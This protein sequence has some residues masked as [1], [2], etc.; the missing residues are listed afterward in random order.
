MRIQNLAPTA[1]TNT[2]AVLNATLQCSGTNADVYVHWGITDGTTNAG[3]WAGS[4]LAGSFTNVASTN[5]SYTNTSLSGG[6]TYYYTFRAMN[7]STNI[8]ATPSWQFSTV[9]FSVSGS[10][11]RFR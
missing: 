7:A 6:R 4:A 2:A 3:A 11:F 8:W 5:I 10:V 9:G 1:I